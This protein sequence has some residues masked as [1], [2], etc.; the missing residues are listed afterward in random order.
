[1]WRWVGGGDDASDD[2]ASAPY[3]G[4]F[5]CGDGV[6]AV[7]LLGPLQLQRQLLG[8]EPLGGNL[9]SVS[10][11]VCVCACVCERKSVYVC[12]CGDGGG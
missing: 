11:C 7:V 3:R 6:F 12:V 10:E 2:G 1:M 8:R 5:E 9:K 4:I